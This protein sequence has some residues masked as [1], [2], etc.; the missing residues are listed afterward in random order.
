MAALIIIISVVLLYESFITDHGTTVMKPE[1]NQKC[2]GTAIRVDYPFYGG[3]IEPH[4]CAQQC[5]DNMQHY[6]LYTNG[7][8]TQCQ[9]L[10][11]CLDWGEDQGVTCSPEAN[12]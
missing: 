10:P 7:Q 11:G 5:E 4:A 12:R 9:I 1:E 3:M 2:I 8:A 6:I